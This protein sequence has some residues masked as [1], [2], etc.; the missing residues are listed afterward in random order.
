[1]A[2]F[3]VEKGPPAQASPVKLVGEPRQIPGQNMVIRAFGVLFG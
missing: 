3:D 2:T 1:M